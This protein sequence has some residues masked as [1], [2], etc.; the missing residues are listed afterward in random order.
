MIPKKIHYCWFGRNPLPELAVNCIESWKKY[1][2]DYEII[3]WN[4]SNF[5]VNICA[6][7]REAYEAKKWAFVSDYARF[8]ILYHEGGLYFDTDVEVVHDFSDIVEKGSFMGCEPSDPKNENSAN[9]GLGLGAEAGLG[10]Y[11][12][13][14]DYY[15][16]QHFSDSM[17]GINTETVVTRTTNILKKHGFKPRNKSVQR[18]AEILVYPPEYFCPKNY[19]TG[20][21][22]VTENTHSIHHY[23]ESWFTNA[24]KMIHIISRA[25]S[26]YGKPGYY[27]ARMLH[28]PFRVIAKIEKLGLR[29]AIKFA[30]K[31]IFR[32]HTP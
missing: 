10:L 17:G 18:V 14:L 5:D 29:N 22:D 28:F 25:F 2:P 7:A 26:K 12:E 16:S 21:L 8:W 9:P 24:D 6:Y 19:H 15:E 30:K 23:S 1:L 20:E 31:K 11:R 3:E 13:I 32:N 4:E 27:V